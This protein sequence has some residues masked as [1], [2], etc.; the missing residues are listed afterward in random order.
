MPS[1]AF[2]S[3]PRRRLGLPSKATC[4]AFGMLA[5]VA[6]DSAVAWGKLRFWGY[7]LINGDLVFDCRPVVNVDDRLEGGGVGLTLVARAQ[8]GGGHLRNKPKD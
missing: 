4:F 1:V 5:I 7:T 2:V 3:A 6:L 8:K